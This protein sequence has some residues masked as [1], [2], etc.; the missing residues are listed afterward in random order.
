MIV[1]SW[2]FL[3]E[4]PLEEHDVVRII[5]DIRSIEEFDLKAGTSGTIISIHR[6]QYG[7]VVAYTIEISGSAVKGNVKTTWFDPIICV[8]AQYVERY[9]CFPKIKNDHSSLPEAYL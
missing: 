8:D 4:P 9:G 6:D 7:F 1:L 5:K 3:L 2:Q